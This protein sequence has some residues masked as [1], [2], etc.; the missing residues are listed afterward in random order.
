MMAS[1]KLLDAFK[2]HLDAFLPP[3]LNILPATTQAGRG[4]LPNGSTSKAK[5]AVARQQATAHPQAY[6]HGLEKIYVLERVNP[7]TIKPLH[8]TPTPKK[9]RRSRTATLQAAQLEF[10]FGSS[11]QH[12]ISPCLLQEPLHVLALSKQ[13][14][15]ALITHGCT[16]LKHVLN[17]EETALT[18]IRGFGQGHADELTQCLANYL[19][20]R[21]PEHSYVV[22]WGAWLRGILA[23][24]NPKAAYLLLES[25]G[26]ESILQL[27]RQQRAELLRLS[28]SEKQNMAL[29][30][31]T[32]LQTQCWHIKERLKTIIKALILPWMRQRSGI[33]SLSELEERLTQISADPHYQHNAWKLLHAIL[34]STESPFEYYLQRIVPEIYCAD[35]ALEQAYQNVVNTT[36]TYF[37]RPG[38]N[39]PLT[40]LI[41]WVGREQARLWHSTS[42][43]WI[44]KV[45]HYAPQLSVRKDR[46]GVMVVR[47][48]L[49]WKISGE[50][51]VAFM[52]ALPS[53]HH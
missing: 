46:Q 34:N 27:N 50:S 38:L 53:N 8:R 42:P 48:T 18:T 10:N 20:E 21:S 4:C 14:E 52:D 28:P 40:D 32:Q 41:N 45:L 9:S 30:A 15:T 49:F 33:A 16:T 35:S 6:S 23:S 7:Q 26:L 3:P 5:T 39:Y 44:A 29:T 12:W 11:W 51:H 37:Y 2:K 17:L 1:M 19:V 13:A 25:Y 47:E 22:E 36:L 31:L 43:A 24:V